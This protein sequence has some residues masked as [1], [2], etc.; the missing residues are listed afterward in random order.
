MDDLEVIEILSVS[1][2]VLFLVKA[3][4]D[5]FEVPN[6]KKSKW[7]NAK[8]IVTKSGYNSIER[9]FQFYSLYFS[10]G[11]HLEGLFSFN[12]ETTHCKNH[13]DTNLVKIFSGY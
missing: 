2:S 1:C 11:R 13:F 10:K 5:H 7:L 9:Y 4:G 6:C 12:L 8:I 3:D